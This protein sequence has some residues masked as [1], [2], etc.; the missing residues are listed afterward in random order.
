[1]LKIGLIDSGMGGISVL[2]GLI[3]GGVLAEFYYLY[4]NKYHPYG[5][6][7]QNELVAIGCANVQKLMEMGVDIIILACNTLT[8]RAVNKLRSMFEI[9]IIGVEPPIKPATLEC[10]NILLLATPSTIKS[11]RVVD[12][13]HKYINK[14]FYFPDMSELANLIEVNFDKKEIIYR[15][16][17]DNLQKY[18]NIEGVVIGCTHYN[19]VVDEIKKIFPSAKIFSN[20][21]GVVKR[22]KYIINKNNFAQTNYLVVRL[23]TTGE[24]IELEKKYFLCKYIDL[25]IEF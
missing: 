5:L 19:Y 7:S 3:E 17:T 24:D 11:D 14:N 15:F 8:S 22:T 10:D 13:I 16:L 1:M 4:D 20:I 21:D 18:N 2:K 9:P 12:M 23:F 25:G 6:K